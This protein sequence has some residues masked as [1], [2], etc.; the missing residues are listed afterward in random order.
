MHACAGVNGKYRAAQAVTQHNIGPAL[1]AAISR[2]MNAAPPV[3]VLADGDGD[4][5]ATAAGSAADEELDLA[6]AAAAIEATTIEEPSVMTFA[7]S[8]VLDAGAVSANS[9]N[10]TSGDTSEV[11]VASG[12][13]ALHPPAPAGMAAASCHPCARAALPLRSLLPGAQTASAGGWRDRT[14]AAHTSGR[15]QD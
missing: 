6:A 10:T 11:G 8:Y 14:G 4:A 15:P 13:K 5:V 2:E 7:T 3:M 1:N 12:E 9:S